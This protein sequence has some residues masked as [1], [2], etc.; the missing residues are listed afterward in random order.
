MS[1]DI[2]VDGN[3]ILILPAPTLGDE[4]ATKEYVDKSHVSQSGV[5]ANV[6]F[7]LPDAGCE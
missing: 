6:F 7:P 1:G 4:P 2:D 3:K 5:Q